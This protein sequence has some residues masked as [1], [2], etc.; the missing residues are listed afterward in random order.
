MQFNYP[1]QIDIP[2][3]EI[4][5]PDEFD[6]FVRGLIMSA[7]AV[8]PTHTWRFEKRS[9]SVSRGPEKKS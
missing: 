6:R 2:H 7:K 1:N 9:A 4:D 5:N 8:W 3:T